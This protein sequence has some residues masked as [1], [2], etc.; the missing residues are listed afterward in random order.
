[1]T[2]FFISLDDAVKFVFNSIER[3]YGGEIFI[4]KMSSIYISDLI[5]IMNKEVKIKI[6]VH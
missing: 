1:M 4:P 2:R 5:K 3:S 6:I